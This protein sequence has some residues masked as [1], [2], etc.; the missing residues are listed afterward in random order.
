MPAV[1]K[2][3]L[4]KPLK[5]RVP[6]PVNIISKVRRLNNRMGPLQIPYAL[7]IMLVHQLGVS[8]VAQPTKTKHPYN[9]V[10]SNRGVV[11][12]KHIPHGFYEEQIKAYF[13]Q[14][15]AVTRARVARSE[16][17]GK[18]KGYAFVEFR[19]PEV[20]K[21]AAETMDNYLMFK[22]VLKTAYIAPE[23][24]KYNY[25]R[26]PVR[27]VTRADG[28][29]LLIT[30]YTQRVAKAVK[31]INAVPTQQQHDNRVE[32][33]L[34]KYVYYYILHGPAYSEWTIISSISLSRDRIRKAQEKLAGL[35]VNVD[36]Q[37]VVHAKPDDVSADGTPV[38][39]LSKKEQK[40]AAAA[41]RTAR[42][43]A[44]KSSASTD[45]DTSATASGHEADVSNLSSAGKKKPK[46]NAIKRKANDTL[47]QL[48][49]RTIGESADDDS[50]DETFHA[51]ASSLGESSFEVDVAASSPRATATRSK[52]RASETVVASKAK[53]SKASDTTL[54]KLLNETIGESADADSAD[55]T[56]N[57]SAASVTDVTIDT[58]LDGSTASV[59]SSPSPKK[60]PKTKQ[61]AAKINKPA[62]AG[63]A[64]KGKHAETEVNVAIGKQKKTKPASVL[65]SN[66]GI[67]KKRAP[68]VQS[69]PVV[70]TVPAKKAVQAKASAPSAKKAQQL[71]QSAVDTVTVVK[72]GNRKKN[73]KA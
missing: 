46:P 44:R 34:Y 9:P 24:Q 2:N 59:L 36:L 15:G 60:A 62:A 1:N 61:I 26:Q 69:Q 64:G 65:L 71:I 56:F 17:T 42:A 33:A 29:K 31:K 54:E 66:A 45:G 27:S 72:A 25:F 13:Q 6:K 37:N 28:S 68:K 8:S 57:G 20:A 5:E 50:S 39:K 4:P 67:Q 21:I 35:S 47:E 30:P 49:N 10:K 70:A 53:K 22:Q 58:S 7:S 12:I 38:Q 18:S 23:E 48:L 32:R 40:A 11:F 55:E 3:K 41:K 52:K 73:K 14:F 51:D 63:K 43:A 19:V 16:R